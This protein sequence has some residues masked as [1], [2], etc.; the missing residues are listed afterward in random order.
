MTAS[1]TRRWAG[2]R[3]AFILVGVTVMSL[4]LAALFL[5]ASPLAVLAPGAVA[6]FPK[7]EN[8]LAMA[9]TAREYGVY[10]AR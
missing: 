8:M 7:L 2:T 4:I 6:E 5:P 10:A 3:P 9:R 1:A